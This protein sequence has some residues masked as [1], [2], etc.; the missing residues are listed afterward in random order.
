MPGA[1]LI[2]WPMDALASPIALGDHRTTIGR[3]SHNTI[4]IDNP[5]ISRFH[6]ILIHQD[7]RYYAKDLNSRNGTHVNDR[8]I[9]AQRI[10]HHDRIRFGKHAFVFLQRSTAAGPAHDATGPDANSTVILSRD[11]ID[12]GQFL[13]Y[14]AETARGSLF[15]GEKTGGSDGPPKKDDLA[16]DHRRLSWLY[17]LSERLRTKTNTAAIMAEGLDLILEAIPSADRAVIMLRSAGSGNLEVTAERNR[18]GAEGDSEFQV[19]R[20]LLNWV[21]TEKIALM[22][23]NATTDSRLQ[24]SESIRSSLLRAVIC[25]PFFAIGKVIGVLYVDSGELT[26]QMAQEDVAF[27]A[28]V[29]NELALTIVNI[30]LQQS[31]IRNERMAAIGLTVSNLAHNIKNL[32]MMNRNASEL[33]DLHLERVDDPEINKCWQIINKGLTRVTDLSMDM[34]EYARER[35]L[36]PASTDVNRA[37]IDHTG[38]FAE[39]LKA[40]GIAL[41]LDLAADNPN[42][43]IDETQ[44][45]RAL[46]NLV[47]NA[48]DA[49]GDRQ[50]GEIRISSSIEAKG[51]LVVAIQ[52]N[53]SGMDAKTQKKVFDLFFTTK[54][55]AGN[56]LGLPMVN[57]FIEASGGRLFLN[58]EKDVGSNLPNGV[59]Q[60]ATT[61]VIF[62]LPFLCA[63][64]V[65][66]DSWSSD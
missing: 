7:G 38:D 17:Q 36:Q 26:Q 53:G 9:T 10:R 34:L 54:G 46:T 47:V 25:V 63:F 49:I 52:D 31:V 21:L 45:Q 57:K 6:A 30:Q 48:V 3:D 64:C 18:S 29:A 37:I 13:T 58:S 42:W 60:K 11:D 28:A 19:S 12:P 8:M 41:R 61:D 20:T 32:T 65:H 51:R 43:V 35:E 5:T 1:Y 14:D 59:P 62:L 40:K 44:F 56:G 2:P 66:I 39:D 16:R 33:M 22:S 23:Q 4:V 24:S 15:P 27:T 50:N 55:S